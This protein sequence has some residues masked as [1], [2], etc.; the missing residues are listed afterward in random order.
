M[1]HPPARKDS[2]LK[3][4]VSEKATKWFF[5]QVPQSADYRLPLGY[6]ITRMGR[7]ASHEGTKS[8]RKEGSGEWGVDF[9]GV[10]APKTGQFRGTFRL[11]RSACFR[12]N[13]CFLGIL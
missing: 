10:F 3:K 6:H 12:R 5:S 9:L 2:D 8:R 7:R 4:T 13:L 11:T 1:P